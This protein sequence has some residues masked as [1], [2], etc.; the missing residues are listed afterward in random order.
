MNCREARKF[1][2]AYG[3]GE[4]A[5]SLMLDVDSHIE[6]CEGCSAL[7]ILNNR[8][9]SEL[10]ELGEVK[11]PEHLRLKIEAMRNQK[12][13]VTRLVIVAAVPLAAAAALLLV[14]ATSFFTGPEE[15]LDKVVEDVVARH[16]GELPMEVS[17][18]DPVEAASWFR[19][20]VDF[21][22]KAPNLGL[23]KASFQGARLSNVREHQAAHM[24][25]SV[26]GHRVT[27]MIFNRHNNHF[28]GGRSIKVADKDVLL[29]R[30][31]GFN[32]A[33]L[34][35]G[36]IAYALSSDLP[37]KRLLSLVDFIVK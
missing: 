25:Y 7:S 37:Q 27:L 36:D 6:S 16:A 24:T 2:D 10:Q 8:L 15:Q 17:G 23:Q 4:L 12:P 20:K 35:D 9:K 18:P 3:D 11:A 13:K 14:L 30:Q 1:L 29:G 5:P 21:P 33:V 34:L 22:V 31:N 26:D 19:G 28:S 32:V